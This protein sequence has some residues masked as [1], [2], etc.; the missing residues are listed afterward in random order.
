M[1]VNNHHKE[2]RREAGA[3]GWQVYR[4]EEI[5]PEQTKVPGATPD[6]GFVPTT[7][8]ANNHDASGHEVGTNQVGYDFVI[9][10][11]SLA[12]AEGET[13]TEKTITIEYYAEVTS[14]AAADTGY[15]N[16]DLV[17]RRRMNVQ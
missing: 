1:I 16:K 7:G 13:A 15:I 17:T 4:S 8:K 2:P 10:I 12:P 9:D 11:N 3:L 6:T 14:A 5:S